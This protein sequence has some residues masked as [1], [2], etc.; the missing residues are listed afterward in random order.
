MQ[1]LAYCSVL[2]SKPPDPEAPGLGCCPTTWWVN[3]IITSGTYHST[4]EIY[5]DGTVPAGANVTFK[6]ATSVNLGG[7]FFGNAGGGVYD[8][9]AGVDAVKKVKPNDL[10]ALAVHSG[11]FVAGKSRQWS[12]FF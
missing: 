10:T 6:G 7:E 9:N 2:W 11:L 8:V 1:I 12:R 4:A 5:S 3:G